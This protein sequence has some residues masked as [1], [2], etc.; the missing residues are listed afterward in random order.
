[1]MS[2]VM[3]VDPGEVLVKFCKVQVKDLETPLSDWI[4]DAPFGMLR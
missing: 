1:M 2:S 4:F 3:G